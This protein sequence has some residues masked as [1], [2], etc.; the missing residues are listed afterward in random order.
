MTSM[1]S[2]RSLIA[3]IATL[4][5][6]GAGGGSARADEPAPLTDA[7]GRGG[8]YTLKE[9]II[10]YVLGADLDYLCAVSGLHGTTMCGPSDNRNYERAWWEL[11]RDNQEFHDAV[12]RRVD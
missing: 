12:Q 7:L 3:G 8:R 10:L 6:V 5:T 1:T 11:Y 2:R 4:L 9:G